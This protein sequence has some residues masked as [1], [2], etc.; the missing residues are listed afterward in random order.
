LENELKTALQPP[1]TPA[2]Q[3]TNASTR[4]PL[5][6][7]V[8]E[9]LKEDIFEFRMP[10]GHRYSEQAL[11]NELGVSRTP[12]RMALHMLARDGYL[13]RLDGHSSWQVKPL[14]LEYYDE[15]YDFRTDIEQLAIRRLCRVDDLSALQQLSEYWHMPIAARPSDFREVAQQDE[16]FH[17]V[18][19]SLAGNREMLRTF[20]KLTEHIRIIRRLDFIN[21]D[22]VSATFDEHGKILDLLMARKDSEAGFLMKAHI[23]TSRAEI[24]HITLHRLSLAAAGQA[25]QPRALRRIG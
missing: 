20:D 17:R 9:R 11:A 13:N 18:I 19:V 23:E 6:Q 8:Y 15:L 16:H 24:K 7:D 22:R 1:T 21:P 3:P 5:V 10:A 4:T 14:D 2:L 25:Q 12:L